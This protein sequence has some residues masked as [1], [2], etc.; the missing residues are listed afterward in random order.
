MPEHPDSQRDQDAC[1][2]ENQ[3]RGQHIDDR[4]QW[5]DE[6]SGAVE[7]EVQADRIAQ[8]AGAP[9][10]P[11]LEH[12]EHEGIAS[13]D[14]IHV[15]RAE[16]ER[17]HHGGDPERTRGEGEPPGAP[18]RLPTRTHGAQ[19]VFEHDPAT[20]DLLADRR[21]DDGR[22]HRG[23]RERSHP[24][25]HL[26]IVGNRSG[27]E[28]LGEI[29]HGAAEKLGRHGDEQQDGER[30]DRRRMGKGGIDAPF[31]EGPRIKTTPPRQE[32]HE[33]E[34]LHGH[35]HH[36]GAVS[37]HRPEITAAKLG[38][39]HAD[40]G[41]GRRHQLLHDDMDAEH[42]RYGEHPLQGMP[43]AAATRRRAARRSFT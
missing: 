14:P 2:D 22:D 32:D 17:L 28:R 35:D 10:D 26:A 1:N 42:A 15:Q 5:L 30:R 13:L 33:G 18:S 24:F 29:Q 36:H 41:A 25:H 8:A 16:G 23:D 21:E 9:V 39:N 27:K 20:K 19:G 6:K 11:C 40:G 3:R 4:R 43:D 34:R 38:N 12:A 31:Y 7:R 37:I